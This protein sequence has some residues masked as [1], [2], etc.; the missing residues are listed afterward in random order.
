MLSIK[1]QSG[2][3]LSLQ[4]FANAD[5]HSVIIEGPK[6]C[7][8]TY[9]A[10]EYAKMLN[11]HDFQLIKPTVNDLREVIESCQLLDNK[12]V[13]CIEN[14]DDGVIAASYTMLKFLEEPKENTYIVITCSSSYRLPDTIISRSHITS[15][16]PPTYSD[17]QEVSKLSKIN[18]EHY[19]DSI[20][21]CI[22]NFGDAIK[23][24]KIDNDK[25]DYLQSLCSRETWRDSV[26]NIVWKLSHWPDNTETPIEIVITYIMNNMN[27]KTI[28]E[29]GCKCLTALEM[30]SLGNH[31]TLCKFAYEGKYIE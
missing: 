8:K 20:K 7:G 28:Y 19:D 15:I 25:I 13:L 4:E 2:A 18:L 14:L 3:I 27:T 22:K 1:S 16:N 17:I 10:Q 21:K 9:L 11:I 24:S 5:K 12:I 23:V 30:K 31:L 26:S 29:A 6:K